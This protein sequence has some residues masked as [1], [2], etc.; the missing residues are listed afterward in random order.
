MSHDQTVRSA[1]EHLGVNRA[2]FLEQYAEQVVTF[3]GSKIGATVL[4]GVKAKDEFKTAPLLVAVAD[5]VIQHLTATQKSGGFEKVSAA[6]DDS[7]VLNLGKFAESGVLSEQSS[8]ALRDYKAIDPTKD[9]DINA[10]VTYNF[11][12]LPIAMENTR[13]ALLEVVALKTFDALQES[14]HFLRPPMQVRPVSA[15]KPPVPN[16]LKL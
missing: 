6:L 1:Y 7:P 15:L 10:L 12:S 16:D 3:S 9:T 5:A 11:K 2:A 13:M 4:L 14:K 8:Q